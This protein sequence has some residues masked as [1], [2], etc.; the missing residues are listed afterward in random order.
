VVAVV[1]LDQIHDPAGADLFPRYVLKG[2]E[3]ALVLFAAAFHGRQDA[4]W[5][6]EAGLTGT[7]VDTDA[8]KLA[9]MTDVYPADWEFVIGDVF[10]YA[11]STGR[12]WD[13]VTVDCPTNLFA[14]CADAL[15]LW[16]EL[17][18]RAVVLG[19]GPNTPVLPPAGWMLTERRFRSGN[20]GGVYWAVLE[21]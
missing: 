21:R 13:V 10:E 15:L 1:T 9:E 2:C 6:Q 12:T 19:C 5:V 17:A 14:A 4:Y 3:T 11:S 20:F 18:D 7:C 16:C 8:G